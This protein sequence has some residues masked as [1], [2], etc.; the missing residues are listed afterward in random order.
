MRIT[1]YNA[2]L[3]QV[4]G[5]LNLDA[6]GATTG[7]K[8]KINSF[9][10]R[11]SREAMQFYWWP[12]TMRVEER[13]MR[14]FYNAGTT[15][16][17]PTGAGGNEVY[18]PGSK[19][20]FQNLATTTGNPPATFTG[21]AWVTDFS[22]WAPVQR[23]YSAPDWLPNTAYA[24]GAQVRD[25]ADG[26]YKQCTTAHTSG[27]STLDGTKFGFLTRFLPYIS[28]DQTDDAGM[29]GRTAVGLVRGVFL[30]NPLTRQRPRRLAHLLGPNGIALPDIGYL[31][32]WLDFQIKPPVLTGMTFDAGTAYGV[33]GTTLYYS[34]A[35]TGFDGDY[36]TS[37]A[38]TSAGES[39]ESAAAKWR[40]QEIPEGLRD[41][42][43]HAAYS[44]ML[45]P[46]AKDDEVS[47]ESTAGGA[48]L[49]DEVRKYM[50]MQRQT[51]TWAFA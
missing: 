3:L 6:T 18:F 25:P 30:D 40:R 7:D 8:T 21:G 49:A 43:A 29:P 20:Y 38:T 28:L 24:Q 13:Y 31:S 5:L 34:S 4:L 35:T 11:R 27:G 39:P 36:W 48:F 51:N 42:I 2:I 45:R 22:R 19:A 50:A 46:I 41:A 23:T 47:I 37:L 44:D 12:E 32:V 10:L 33:V 14:P 9:I 16:A 1:S 17:A 15:Y 26:F